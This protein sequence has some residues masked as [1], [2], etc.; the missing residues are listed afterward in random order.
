MSK[1]ILLTLIVAGL[2]GCAEPKNNI[3][4][5]D[6]KTITQD[7]LQSWADRVTL[8]RFIFDFTGNK[9]YFD[10]VSYPRLMDYVSIEDWHTV[11]DFILDPSNE[12]SIHQWLNGGDIDIQFES[13]NETVIRFEMMNVKINS[14]DAF[15]LVKQQ[16]NNQLAQWDDSMANYNCIK[17][18]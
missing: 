17:N 10:L 15:K 3:W 5:C 6:D 8:M 1:N 11:N 2:V 14:W 18:R 4:V 12:T 7:E 16:E 13:E 9:A